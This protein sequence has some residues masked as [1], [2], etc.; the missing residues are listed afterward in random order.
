MRL[1]FNCEGIT[2][3]FMAK[4]LQNSRAKVKRIQ[5]FNLKC[6]RFQVAGVRIDGARAET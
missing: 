1:R 2:L 6:F 3:E 4:I 5:A